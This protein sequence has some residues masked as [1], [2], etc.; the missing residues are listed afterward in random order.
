MFAWLY[1]YLVAI[2]TYLLSWIGI[3]LPQNAAT[4]TDG[5]AESLIPQQ[6]V[7]MATATTSLTAESS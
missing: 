5:S 2:V 6:V 1:E 7:E 3:S 4:T